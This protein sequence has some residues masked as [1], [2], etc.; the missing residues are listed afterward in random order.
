MVRDPGVSKYSVFK[1]SRNFDGVCVGSDRE[2][3]CDAFA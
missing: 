3:D 2:L 1:N